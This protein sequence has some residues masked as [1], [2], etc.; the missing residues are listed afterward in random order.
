MKFIPMFIFLSVAAVAP[1]VAW[2]Q[3]EEAS[4]M[5]APSSVEY[6]AGEEVTVVIT[7]NFSEPA[8]SLRIYVPYDADLLRVKEIQP[9]TVNFPHWWSQEENNS[10]VELAASVPAPGIQGELSVAT[11]VFEAIGTGSS[12]FI[13]SE[14]SLVLNTQNENML[15]PEEE[16]QV[17][18]P[19]AAPPAVNDAPAGS[20][21]SGLGIIIAV[22][23]VIA[24]VGGVML[25]WL[26]SK[27]K[28]K[29]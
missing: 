25:L 1:F 28:Q 22:F 10:V 29:V 15:L 5:I 8:T 12:E 9:D 16:G 24:G 21:S 11:I 26:R 18:S 7:V 3:G 20:Q 17:I 6:E 13:A 14:D 19:P 23:I 2:G 4:I 27:N